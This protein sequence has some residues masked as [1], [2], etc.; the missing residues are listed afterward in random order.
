MLIY[1]AS[2]HAKVIIDCLQSNDQQ[3]KAIFDDNPTVKKLL[4]YEVEHH[5][6]PGLYPGE[7]LIIAIGNNQIRK[8]I[9]EKV[10]DSNPPPKALCHTT[11][12]I[13]GNVQMGKGVVVLHN[14]VIQSSTQLGNHVIVNTGATVDHD[15][16]LADFVHI[17]PNA[18]LCGGVSVGEGTLIGAGSV[19][20]PTVKIG[21]WSVIGAGAVVK[22][23]IPDYS[24]VVG[25]PG[26]IVKR[27]DPE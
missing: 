24:M 10:A 16:K 12:I 21:A 20:I 23:D 27:F 11:S 9:A 13:S 14:S 18:T 2:G 5:Y 22:E 17:A 1:G 25:N 26:R 3:V 15:C 7:L 6:A 8:K 19:V 4:D